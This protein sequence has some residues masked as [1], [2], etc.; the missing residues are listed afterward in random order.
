MSLLAPP[1]IDSPEA[2]SPLARLIVSLP[3]PA[4]IVSAPSPPVMV[5][6]LALPVIEKASVCPDSVIVTP[7]PAVAAEIASIPWIDE[8]EAPKELRSDDVDVRL[9]VSPVPEPRL[10][11]PEPV[12][13]ALSWAPVRVIES[14]PVVP[15]R[16]PVSMLLIVASASCEMSPLATTFSV[17]VKPLTRLT[18]PRPASC[19]ADRVTVSLLV[20]PVRVSTF[21]TV[22]REKSTVVPLVRTMVSL[23]A[24]PSIDSPE[25]KSPLARLIV[26]LPAPAA[27]VSA[28]SPPV[29]VSALALPVIEKASV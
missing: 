28:P 29:M 21:V 14:V 20:L 15:V 4:A 26:S 22:P 12:R 24:P 18:V 6:A 9:I 7:A 1:S 17:S 2:K 13:I 19:N 16:L 27:I 5:S 25:A 3:P 23:L 8:F 10:M 11:V